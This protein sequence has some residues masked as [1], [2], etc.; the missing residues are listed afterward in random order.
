MAF[1]AACIFIVKS[2]NAFKVYWFF[3]RSLHKCN[4]Q[5]VIEFYYGI[6]MLAKYV[7]KVMKKKESWE[8]SNKKKRTDFMMH[9]RKEEDK[10][11]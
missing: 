5:N 2:S 9:I 1:F 10:K 7:R 6:N 3:V 8:R 11:K 4:S